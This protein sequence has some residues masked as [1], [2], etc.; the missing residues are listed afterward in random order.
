M[1]NTKK[2]IYDHLKVEEKWQQAWE[3]QQLFQN[4]A[5]GEVQDPM[6]LLFAF[7]YPSGSGL[8]VGHVESKTALDILA[9][10][11]RMNGKDV[12]FPV[13]WDAFG[14]PA[15]NYAIKTGTPPAVT[16]KNAIN[17]F[18]EQLKR[19]GISYDWGGE[20]A[21]SHPGYYKWTQWIFLELFKEGLAYQKMGKVNWCPGC[22]TV[23]ANEQVIEGLCERCDS[24]VEQ[25][26]MKQWYFQI[27]KYQDELISGLDQVDW[28][29]PTKQQQLNWIGKSEGLNE[30]WQVDGMDLTLES[31]TTWPHTT[32][33]ATFIVIAPEHPVI[34]K[35][36]KG[37]DQEQKVKA[38]CSEAINDKA[39]GQKDTNK[40][41]KGVFTGKY[42]INPLTGWKMPVWVANF[43]IMEYGTGI[44][45]A[46]P[47][48]DERDFAFALKYDLPIVKVIEYKNETHA[49]V[50]KESV[51]DDFIFKI[52][53]SNWYSMEYLDEGWGIVI[54]QGKADEF[55]KLVQESMVDGLF[56]VHTDGER[57]V[58][59]FK[60]K[61]FAWD[62]PVA[63]EH[64]RKLGIP[65]KEMNWDDPKKY[66]FCYPGQGVMVNAG[67][68][69]GMKTE[70]AREKIIKQ[71]IKKGYGKKAT[72]YRLRDWL[73]S[74]QRYW[75][76]PIPIIYDPEGIA[77]PIKDKDLPWKLAEDV[78]FKPTGESPLSSSKELQAR[79]ESYAARS[80]ADL[81]AEKGWDK[82]GKGWRPEYDTM[83]T[84]VCSSWYYLRY[85][86]PRNSQ[87]F[88]SADQLKKWLPV[89]FYMIGPE[90]IVLHLLYSRFFTKFLRDQG[91]LDFD[92][93]FMKMR[94]Q[95]MILG[96]DG[97]KMSKSKGN[98][99]NPDDV[100]VKFGADTLR[101]YEMFMGPI[102]ADKAWDV[103]A[104]AGV[105]RFFIRIYKLMTE[106]QARTTENLVLTRKLHQT[107]KKVSQDIPKLKF[108]TA[109]AAMM[110]FIN[111]WDGSVKK[112]N[113]L[114]VE[115]KQAFIK[116][117]A[118]FAPF[119]AEELFQEVVQI[120]QSSV[121]L[122]E[123]PEFDADMAKEHQ[124]IIPIQIN[125][126][127]RGEITLER[128]QAMS[129]TEQQ[130]FDLAHQLPKIKERLA[131]KE[132]I[133]TIYVPG[134]VIN[135]VI[136]N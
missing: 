58:V 98:V 41:K 38:F 110:E 118:P 31:F 21:T 1:T 23:L 74:R 11:Y 47:A 50:L 56:Y 83:D 29:E 32:W 24:E 65:E 2:A 114:S 124:L 122:S 109:I 115:Q 116:L 62:D 68:L 33:G 6:Y 125:G 88:A 5:G 22:Q 96:P 70:A 93:P 112:G 3:N 35:L 12:F 28:P 78:D 54:P 77:H 63:K 53:S 25:K 26:D 82:T 135:I 76:A 52:Q 67:D 45:K 132:V 18:R 128:Q 129:S 30:T 133:K 43:A 57:Q 40:E 20:I 130:V 34:E 39:G 48:H 91:Y 99:I 79:T 10:Y 7:A 89:D 27:T 17:T 55:I 71:A 87:E 84:F 101:T 14:L 80:Y 123:W 86:D 108:N 97:K 105:Y 15:E 136:K 134:R 59:I 94:H 126:K 37:T 102:E 113:T 44:V 36:V 103:S 90:H 13:G 4:T 131:N 49:V 19:I 100:I 60:D 81:I 106:Q 42:V 51:N 66:A 46:C 127:L 117:L 111:T 119:L 92:E 75:G 95:G 85:T 16:T 107:I 69:T 73:I 72:T 64:A 8:H 121:H 120:K 104:V 9:R 61:V